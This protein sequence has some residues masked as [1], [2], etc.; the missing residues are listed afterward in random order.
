MTGEPQV[1]RFEVIQSNQDEPQPEKQAQPKCAIRIQNATLEYPL[2]HFGQRSLKSKLLWL[3]GHREVKQ[4]AK[5]ITALKD[6][7]LEFSVGERVAIVGRNGAG[8]SSILRALAGVYP[9]KTGSISVRGQI[10]TLL[11]IGLGFEP[12]STGRENIY[13][14][15]MAMGYSRKEL[16]AVEDEIVEFA[17]LGSFIDLPVRTYSSGMFVRLGFSVSTQFTPEVLLIDEV[18]GAGDAAFAVRALKRME[19]I[20]NQ[21][22][23]MITATHDL[24]LVERICS[25]VI[26]MEEG[27]VRMDGTPQEVLPVFKNTLES[28]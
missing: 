14:R 3:F 6:V 8:K 15:G 25:R 9:L 2:G 27:T 1:R 4:P 13:Y 23:I 28:E 10:G 20:V 18:F 5:S 21:S 11:D 12:E 19:S 22:G 16:S 26:W 17:D 7:S 24:T